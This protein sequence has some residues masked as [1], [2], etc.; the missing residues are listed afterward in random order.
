MRSSAGPKSFGASLADVWSRRALLA[1]LVTRDVRERYVGTA[2]GVL[3]IFLQPALLVAF[4]TFIFSVVFEVRTGEAAHAVT[5]TSG[6]G[7]YALFVLGG[8]VPWLAFADGLNRAARSVVANK[9]IITKV[10]F[11]VELLPIASVTSAMTAFLAMTAIV[12]VI[13]GFA[14]TLS[15]HVLW[16]PVITLIVA[17]L[18]LGVGYFLAVVS[19]FF[20]DV[21]N[22]VPFVMTLWLYASPVLYAR[23]ALPATVAPL[24]QLN[25]MAPVAEAFRAAIV[26]GRAPDLAALAVSFGVAAVAFLLGFA[27][28]RRAQALFVEVL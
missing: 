11:P 8:L 15:V 20:R 7:G 4:Y 18:A 9:A 22:L 10:L 1:A 19:T 21:T 6:H 17:L 16:L 24:M 14:G 5:G 23:E 28:F 25:P 2:L 3:W 26:Q 13:S 27:L 12:V